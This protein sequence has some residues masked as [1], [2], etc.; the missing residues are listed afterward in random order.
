MELIEAIRRVCFQITDDDLTMLRLEEEMLTNLV[1]CNKQKLSTK[2]LAFERIKKINKK[3][4]EI[5][6][7]M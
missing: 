5:L 3:Q 4:L 2:K 1:R 6:G 7:S